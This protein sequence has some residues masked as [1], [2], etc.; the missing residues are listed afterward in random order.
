VAA[1]VFYRVG[2][3]EFDWDLF[4]STLS[5]IDPAWLTAS[6]L[7]ILVSYAGRA[8]RWQVMLRPIKPDAGFWNLLSATV[9]GFAA[10]VVLGRPGELVRPYLISVKERVTFSSQVAMWLLERIYDLLIV[11]ILFGVAL[12]QV[13]PET[14]LGSSLQAALRTGGYVAAI[15][16][17]VSVA[18]LVFVGTFSET[19]QRRLSQALEAVPERYRVRIEQVLHSFA[20]GMASTSNRYFVMQLV[21]Y[22]VAEWAVIVGGIYFLLRAYPPTAHFSLMDTLVFAGCVSFGNAVQIPGIGGGLQV[23]AVI[24]LTELFGLQLEAATGMA[25][26]LWLVSWVLIAP[27]GFVLA[28]A[29]GMN[30]RSFRQMQS[31]AEELQKS[32]EKAVE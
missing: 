2:G 27:F 24:V 12:T 32:E 29:E 15:L 21:A 14:G 30:W 10:L 8:L 6:A 5:R 13:K 28:G 22:S 19:A 7:L 9:I 20:G 31:R 3:A 23:V 11:L 25:I 18:I 1:I 16:A 26:M 4:L 17:L